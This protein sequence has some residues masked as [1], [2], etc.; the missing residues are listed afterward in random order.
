MCGFETIVSLSDEKC[1]NA[2]K[3]KRSTKTCAYWGHAGRILFLLLSKTQ[4]CKILH[5]SKEVQLMKTS[6]FSQFTGGFLSFEKRAATQTSQHITIHKF[7]LT[8]IPL[9]LCQSVKASPFSSIIL[10]VM[11]FPSGMLWLSKLEE[12]HFSFSTNTC[13][14]S[15]G[16]KGESCL[17]AL[18]TAPDKN[19]A[20]T[21]PKT[22][23]QAQQCTWGRMTPAVLTYYRVW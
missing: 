1:R 10:S 11:V 3:A 19:S 14:N 21:I 18:M 6:L 9:D 8:Q 17:S 7:I 20:E 22:F 5:E 4:N 15:G 2:E 16:A 13:L 12:L 23:T